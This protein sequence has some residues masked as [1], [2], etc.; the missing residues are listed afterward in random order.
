MRA[1]WVSWVPKCLIRNSKNDLKWCPCSILPISQ[2]S[3][4][5]DIYAKRVIEKYP[6]WNYQTPRK[7]NNQQNKTGLSFSPFSATFGETWH[8]DLVADKPKLLLAKW[9]KQSSGLNMVYT[10]FFLVLNSYSA[11]MILLNLWKEGLT[12]CKF[13]RST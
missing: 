4:Y 3:W 11:L 6:K 7:P 2:S 13:L 12:N 5:F 10:E 8:K 1:Y 9:S